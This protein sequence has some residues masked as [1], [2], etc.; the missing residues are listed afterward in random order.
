MTG[1]VRC[2]Q[3]N[4]IV[5]LPD[6]PDIDAFACLPARALAQ[7]AIDSPALRPRDG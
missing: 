7:A 4:M 6:F 2:A 5:L 1:L 3:R